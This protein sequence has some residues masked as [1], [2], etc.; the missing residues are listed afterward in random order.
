MVIFT[1]ENLSPGP[2]GADISVGTGLPNPY[3]QGDEGIHGYKVSMIRIHLLPLLAAMDRTLPSIHNIQPQ[4]K[5]D[6]PS[7]Y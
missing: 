2:T 6:S 4:Q 1:Q 5:Y 7:N 3:N